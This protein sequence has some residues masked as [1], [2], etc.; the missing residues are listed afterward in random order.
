MSFTC[1]ATGGV[2]SRWL[3]STLLFVAA[4]MDA[5]LPGYEL[6]ARDT[7]HTAHT[8][9]ADPTSRPEALPR[10]SIELRSLV[11]YGAGAGSE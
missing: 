4:E 11:F 5:E 6:V 3:E 8:S 9:F 7:R 2:T 1:R 10:Q